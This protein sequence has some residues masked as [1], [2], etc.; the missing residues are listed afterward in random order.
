MTND[1]PLLA[2]LGGANA[3]GLADSGGPSSASQPESSDAEGSA[4]LASGPGVG[5]GLLSG[6]LIG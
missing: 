2:G 3:G 1:V 6:S 5:S 4:L